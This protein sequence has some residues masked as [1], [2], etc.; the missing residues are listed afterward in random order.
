[1]RT[2]RL[3][4]VSPS[5]HCFG[6]VYIRGDVPAGGV[7]A[8]GMYLPGVVPAGGYLLG[9]YLPG[10]GGVPAW[11]CTCPL[12]PPPVDRHIPVKT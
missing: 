12:P 4:P 6:G 1:M 2:A 3:L 8:R 7:P 5:M 10:G 11:G 9:V